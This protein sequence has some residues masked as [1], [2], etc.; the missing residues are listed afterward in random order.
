[1]DALVFDASANSLAV[2]RVP[3]P[4]PGEGEVLVRVLRAQICSTVSEGSC[5]AK[6]GPHRRRR[7]RAARAPNTPPSLSTPDPPPSKNSQD[8]EI[9]RGYIPCFDQA[10]G[11]EFVGVIERVPA[12]CPLKPGTRVASEINCND[13]RF[14]CIDALF[15][16]NHAPG[17]S[18]LGIINRPGCCAEYVTVPAKNLHAVPQHVS[19][20]EACFAEPLAA[21]LRIVEQGVVAVATMR[22]ANE[23][24]EAARRVLADLAPPRRTTSDDQEQQQKIAVLGDGKL[25]LLVAQVLSLAVPGRVT[26]FGRHPEKMALVRGGGL[27]ARVVVGKEDDDGDDAPPLPLEEQFHV[28]VEATGSQRGIR[29]AL[30]LARPLGAVVLKSTV[31]A[32]AGHGLAWADVANVAVVQELALLGS[33]CGPIDAAVA[34]LAASA[35]VRGLV[36]DMVAAEF[37]LNE[38]V[39]AM[40]KAKEKGVLKVAVVVER[41]GG[42]SGGGAAGGGAPAA[43]GV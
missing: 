30:R 38:G 19:D 32:S 8:I 40:A 17:R 5:C 3:I 31:S 41:E 14:S 35:D 23:D 4:E 1:M 24:E 28:V 2:K 21:A 29:R 26:L 18:V 6:T 27:A 13:L 11:H 10:L 34:L 16:R 7:R 20:A 22:R 43:G 37:P 36:R 15:E 25:G 12:S 39:A 33:R 42:A 9:T